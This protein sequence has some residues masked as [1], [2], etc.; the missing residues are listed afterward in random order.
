VFRALSHDPLLTSFGAESSG[1]GEALILS[2]ALAGTTAESVLTTSAGGVGEIQAVPSLTLAEL[3]GVRDA[4]WANYEAHADSSFFSDLVELDEQILTL[5]PAGHPGR[6]DACKRLSTSLHM[7]SMVKD[8]SSASES[9]GSAPNTDLDML[10]MTRGALW[11]HYQDAR[12]TDSLEGMICLD[13]QILTLCAGGNVARASACSNLAASLGLRSRH[14]NSTSEVPTAAEDSPPSTS[15]PPSSHLLQS[16]WVR[17]S[18]THDLAVL[19]QVIIGAEAV[20]DSLPADDANRVRACQNLA[21]MLREKYERT[22][23]VTVLDQVV[24]IFGEAHAICDIESR[25]RPVV[26]SEYA[27]SLWSV[28][29][30]TRDISLL[31]QVTELGREA[32]TFRPPGHPDR[33][34]SCS[35]LAVALTVYC[36]ETGDLSM[37]NDTIALGREALNLRF[38]GHPDRA[39]SCTKLAASL[40]I[41]CG[42]QTNDVIRLIEAIELLH[43]ALSLSPPGHPDRAEACTNLARSIK[44]RYDQTGDASLLTE[45]VG[46]LR[47]ALSASPP[48]HNLVRARS[49][50]NLASY[51]TGRYHETGDISLLTEAIE[52]QREAI[53]LQPHGHPERA[54]SSGSLAVSL[55][56]RYDQTGDVS[57]LTEVIELE[58]EGLSLVPSGHPD[59][60]M[61][62]TN[63]AISLETLYNQTGD[64]GLLTEATKLERE[65]L[66]LQPAGHPGRATS[67]VNLAIFLTRWFKRIG[68]VNLIT[69]AIELEREALSLR[70]PGHPDRAI[71]CANLAGS[72]KTR[73]N[74]TGDIRL[75]DEATELHREAL[76]LHPSGH[77]RRALSYVNLAISLGTR[78]EQ[79]GDA[80]VLHE[81][82]DL[83]EKAS[84]CS[85]VSNIWQS[86][87]LQCQLHLSQHTSPEL[88]IP[89]A[90]PCLVQMSQSEADDMNGFMASISSELNKF[91]ALRAAWTDAIPSS[92]VSVYSNA[93]DRLPLMAAFVLNTTERLS[94]LRSFTRLGSQACVVAIIAQNISRAIELLEHAHGVIW[95]QALHQRDPQLDGVPPALASELD[96]LLRSIA[97]PV[98]PQRS[99]RYSTSQDLRH[100]QN[101]R[102]QTILDEIRAMRGLDRFMRGSTFETLR[103]VA[104]DH[105]VVVLVAVDDE[106]YALIISSSSQEE[107]DVMKL[108]VDSKRMMILGGCAKRGLQRASTN[109]GWG[110]AWG[111]SVQDLG[112]MDNSERKMMPAGK[113]NTLHGVLHELWRLVVKPVLVRLGLEVSRLIRPMSS[114]S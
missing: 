94:A 16:L 102:I 59:R 70:P 72:L 39:M 9:T 87:A 61:S 82:I 24:R 113:I 99:D 42:N 68:D 54:I 104:H 79:T 76:T 47:E 103:E 78:Y 10:R 109:D 95:A 32:L 71:P 7:A 60:A 35:A 112:D 100:K 26:C 90:L 25:H 101:S 114:W 62:C 50:I 55:A 77:T 5:C 40:L 19:E 18:E 17:Y 89:R 22:G 15:V 37:L 53:S 11:E 67:C 29:R 65:A 83:S 27:V 36:E 31:R 96:S 58:R 84:R 110:D 13:E 56:A 6:M 57:L 2:H 30:L 64:V 92:L 1:P 106:S 111:D 28:Y 21:A 43:E 4:L 108:E 51:L 46:L 86:L 93:I 107:P 48:G 23:D 63:L 105:P 44:A 20:L 14:I 66:S 41:P 74:Q 69:E 8:T 38:P 80:S 34:T 3:M 75:L 12:D 52:L 88:V 73:Y 91:W 98:I 49:C 33:A 85:S 97:L 45:I 81:A